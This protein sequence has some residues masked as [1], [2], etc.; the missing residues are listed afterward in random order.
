ML[1]IARFTIAHLF[2]HNFFFSFLFRT[3]LIRFADRGLVDKGRPNTGLFNKLFWTILLPFC[4]NAIFMAP[5]ISILRGNFKK[6]IIAKICLRHPYENDDFMLQ[7]GVPLIF[8]AIIKFVCNYLT[9]KTMLFVR[10][11]CPNNRMSS[12]GNYVRNFLTFEDTCNFILYYW[13]WDCCDALLIYFTYIKPIFPLSPAVVAAIHNI[14]NFIFYGF[15]YCL[16]LPII[17]IIPW[18]PP[19]KSKHSPPFYVRQEKLEPRRPFWI[20]REEDYN[21]ISLAVSTSSQGKFGPSSFN[22]STTKKQDNVKYNQTSEQLFVCD[23]CDYTCGTEITLKKHINT[24]HQKVK[25][26]CDNQESSSVLQN[27][28]TIND[29]MTTKVTTVTVTCS[30]KEAVVCDSCLDLYV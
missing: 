13:L 5:V 4:V 17:M 8:P 10:G 26:Y 7:K 23:D 14:S 9:F 30:C 11:I 28:E 2:N 1:F 22:K 12:I 6:G 27:T 20:S 16:V 24:K 19:N 25:K 21:R 29:S 15:F 18:N 3:V